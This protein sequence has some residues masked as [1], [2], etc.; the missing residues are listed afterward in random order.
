MMSTSKYFAAALAL[1]V[2][3]PAAA[4][5]A[6]IHISAV[7]P[8]RCEMNFDGQLA[9][10]SASSFNLGTVHQFCN[11]RYQM[12]LMHAPGP[13]GAQFQLGGHIVSAGA[14]STMVESLG[15]PVNGDSQLLAH[16]LDMAGA[17]AIGS[18]LT[19]MVTPISF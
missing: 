15:N 18:S 10:L 11:T 7:V 14:G 13:S 19:V 3:A 2:A 12:V 17:D 16:G 8:M 5:D 9:R 1:A 4:S 6:R